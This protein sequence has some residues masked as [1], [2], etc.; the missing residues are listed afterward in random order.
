MLTEKENEAADN[1]GI[2]NRICLTLPAGHSFAS[3]LENS[4]QRFVLE[5][6]AT[7]ALSNFQ[8]VEKKTLQIEGNGA[9]ILQHGVYDQHFIQISY[10]G[11]TTINI[12]ES[13]IYMG[14]VKEVLIKSGC[15]RG[16]EIFSADCTKNLSVC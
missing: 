6:N 16:R 1:G 10:C 9:T 2:F 3:D 15:A 13:G 5:E 12:H 4:I 8:I 11:Q 14:G 7:Y